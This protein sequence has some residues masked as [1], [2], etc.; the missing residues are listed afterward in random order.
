MV[1][2][3]G[4]PGTR[5]SRFAWEEIDCL[6]VFIKVVTSNSVPILFFV[7]KLCSVMSVSTCLN[8]RC[9]VV[10]GGLWQGRQGSAHPLKFPDP[11]ARS[12]L[13]GRNFRLLRPCGDIWGFRQIQPK[14]AQVACPAQTILSLAT[15]SPKGREPTVIMMTHSTA[16]LLLHEAVPKLANA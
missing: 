11:S 4:Y 10:A 1:R 9:V 7:E 2:D 12:F 5:V 14:D 15:R 13:R 8:G 6:I 3:P 16:R